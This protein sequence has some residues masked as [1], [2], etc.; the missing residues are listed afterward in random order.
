MRLRHVVLK[1]LCASSFGS[2]GVAS[3]EAP[4]GARLRSISYAGSLCP[5]YSTDAHL[6]QARDAIVTQ[7]SDFE[8]RRGVAG[9]S[10]V[11]QN[12]SLNIDLDVPAGW[13][14]AIQG[15]EIRAEASLPRGAL[16]VFRARPYSNSGSPLLE[17]QI[18]G[19]HEGPFALHDTIS[20]SA[21]LWSVCGQRRA[22]SLQYEV[23]LSSS[24]DAQLR[25]EDIIDVLTS[26]YAL[27]WRRCP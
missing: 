19:A 12:C 2:A 4:T 20:P 10:L 14:V 15:I 26:T 7:T 13:A 11:R 9:P 24:R 16:A 6:T 23:R 18:A 5:A 25:G 3:A 8:L 1:L 22:I 17:A 21:L 27:K